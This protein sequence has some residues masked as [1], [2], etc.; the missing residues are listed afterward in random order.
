MKQYSVSCIAFAG[1]G[2]T[3]RTNHDKT[4]IIEM[5]WSNNEYLVI[6]V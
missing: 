5:L 2:N 1:Y 3:T 4:L 6:Y